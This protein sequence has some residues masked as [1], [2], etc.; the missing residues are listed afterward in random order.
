MTASTSI[1]ETLP[2]SERGTPAWEIAELFPYQGDWTEEDYLALNTNKLIEFKDGVL[3]FLPFVMPRHQDVLGSLFDE[4]RAYARQHGLHKPYFA[5]LRVRL[6]PGLY[7][8]PDI[9]L[10][11][12]EHL[13]DLDSPLTGALLVMEIVS[14][15]ARD[16]KRDLEEK[17]ADYA[18]AGIPEYWIVDPRAERIT[19]LT[20]AAVA[21][22]YTVHG[23]FRR[24]DEASSALFPGF[25][26]EVARVFFAG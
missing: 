24:G 22:D 18:A 21:T 14:G 10:P 20:L 12:A 7:R 2:R 3:E 13:T 6:R 5:P 23:E 4:L 9:I 16:R 19:V 1:I 11:G 26:I 25:S 8:E 15:D 17:R